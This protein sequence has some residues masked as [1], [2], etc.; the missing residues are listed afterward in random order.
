MVNSCLSW[1]VSGSSSDTIVFKYFRTVS[2]LFGHEQEQV[3]QCIYEPSDGSLKR[4]AQPKMN[5]VG[6]SSIM[7]AHLQ[8][9]IFGGKCCI[10]LPDQLL[11]LSDQVLSV[12]E[13]FSHFLHCCLSR[14]GSQR[15]AWTLRRVSLVRLKHPST[16][17]R[18]ED[19]P[20]HPGELQPIRRQPTN[21]M[22]SPYIQA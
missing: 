8:L 17:L 10:L 20:A 6:S 2:Q 4:R 1:V 11:Q 19:S 16:H 22:S 15:R 18:P 7:S 14:G 12:G 5:T 13:P 3:F 9:V 21:V